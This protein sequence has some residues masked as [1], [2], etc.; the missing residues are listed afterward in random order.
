MQ[1]SGEVWSDEKGEISVKILAEVKEAIFDVRADNETGE[2]L[3]EHLGISQILFQAV[4]NHLG[5]N[6]QVGLNRQ[7][8]A[9]WINQYS[10]ALLNLWNGTIDI[11]FVCVV[12]IISYIFIKRKKRWDYCWEMHK[13]KLLRREM[14]GD[15]YTQQRCVLRRLSIGCIYKLYLCQ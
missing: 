11:Q 14:G 13:G 5:R 12:Y 4:F 2:Q 8:N 6:T 3:F 10:K 9:V 7:V 15:V 1:E